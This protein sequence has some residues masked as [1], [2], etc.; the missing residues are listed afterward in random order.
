MD[1]SLIKSLISMALID[2]DVETLSFNKVSQFASL[3]LCRVE[4][5]QILRL[6]LSDDE[7]EGH[8]VD[9]SLERDVRDSTLNHDLSSAVL[10][11]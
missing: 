2:C 1:G 5:N 6:C 7:L 11:P 9:T 3:F 4:E 10:V 8:S